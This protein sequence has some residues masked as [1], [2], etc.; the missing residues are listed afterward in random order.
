VSDSKSYI[1]AET[2]LISRRIFFDQDIYE[3][4]LER[5]FA[6]TWLFLGHETQIENPGDYMTAY[7]GEDPVILVRGSDGKVR[8]FLNSCRHRGM[9]V[10]RADRGNADQWTCSFHGWTYNNKG[11][12][13]GVPQEDNYGGCLDKPEWGLLEVPSLTS[14]GGFVF[15][16]W[17]AGAISLD[18]FLGDFRWYLDIMLERHLGGIEFVPGQQRYSLNSNWK[19]ASENFTGDTYHLAYSHG[20][21]FQLDIRQLN[22][23]NPILF[24]DGGP[25]YNVCTDHGHGMTGMVFG[26]ERYRV[27][28]MV[29]K[30]MGP[31]VVD[32]VEASNAKLKKVLSKQQTDAYAL[33]FGNIF[34]NFSLNDFSALRPIG[35]Y[36]WHPKGPS[37]MEAWQW[38]GVDRDAPQIIKDNA[39]VDFTRTQSISGIAAQDDTENFEQVTEA[40]RGVVG[41]RLDFNYQMELGAEPLAGPDGVPGRF[42][43][44]IS[45]SNQRNFYGYWAELFDDPWSGR[46]HG[47]QRHAARG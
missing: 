41:Q 28:Q 11:E 22:P 24:K 18:D 29:A 16:S 10:C 6:R 44:Y 15:G 46:G 35:F 5:I 31:E 1:D 21:M 2:G 23:A 17:D 3:Q 25:Y 39:R 13:R 38:C 12:L 7:M 20:S 45:E 42:A 14:Y 40:T 43:P 26:G 37:R 36:V 30:E 4:E 34:P 19:I 27:D 32:Y 9:K 8:A 47:R 33:S